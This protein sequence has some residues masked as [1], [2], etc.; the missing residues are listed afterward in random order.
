MVEGDFDIPD[1]KAQAE[2]RAE[3]LRE[4]IR[5]HDRKYYLEND[6]EISDHEYDMLVK[7]LEA[8]EDRY[9]ELITPD[10]PTQ[11]VLSTEIDEFETVEHMSAMLSLDNTYNHEELRDFDRRVREGIGEEDKKVEYVVEPKIDG[12]GVALFYEDRIFQ[13]GSTR[14]DGERGEDITPNL[15]TVHTIPLRLSEDTLLETAEFRGEVYMPRDR[16]EEM[17]ERRKD[18]DKDPF[19]NPR[20]AAAGTVRNK[21]PSVVAERP[22]D[23]FI[24]T[25]S[26]HEE[27]E[28]NTHWECMKEME[29]AGLKVNRHIAKKE[30]IEEVIDYIDQWKEKKEDLNY[31]I[32]GMVVKVNKLD[33]HDKLGATSKH[34]RWAIAYKYPAMRKTSTIKDIEVQV[35]RTG[36]LTPI[37]ILEPVQ[38]SGTT[39]E[40]ASLHNQDELERQEV[41]IGDRVLVEKA[42]EIIPQVLKVT[43]KKSEGVFKLPE[44]CPVC[45]S[46]AKR[47]GDEVARRCLNANCPAQVKQKLEHWGSRG[48]MDIEGLGP[49]ILDKI[50]EKEI[51]ETIPDLYRI[52]KQD[53]IEIERMAEKSAHNLLEEIEDSKERGLHRVLYGLGIRFVGDHMADVLTEHFDSIHELM[54]ADEEEL[55]EIDE[56]GPET[57]ESVVRFFHDEQNRKMIGELKELGVK[58][59]VEKEE[60]FEQFL[61]GKKF[62]FTGAL[63]EY[64]RN[65]ASEL[66][67][68]F[69]GRATSSVSGA[70]DYLVVGENPGSKL[71]DAIEEGTAIL[72][73]KDFL[74]MLEAKE[75]LE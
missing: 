24:Y 31:E 18:E 48:A 2:E 53:L 44:K 26:Y 30:G 68:K 17:N 49:K 1:S 75:V 34:P 51:V 43:E 71:D 59:E 72:E 22:L 38:L 69:G 29:K 10:S 39:V 28:F 8:I 46:E 25:L 54:E 20:N 7:E 21:D 32:D 13:R 56:V 9:P 16:F 67:E 33:Y 27:G 52:K 55:L 14:G 64:T 66:V 15:K 74:E 41:N 60:E 42:G 57:A 47:L 19:A 11:R 50:V 62:V 45:G 63:D 3:E 73:E 37:A 58:M 40:R 70:T 6:P 35:G 36:K 12:L 5:Y 65:E 61:D 23:V 4:K